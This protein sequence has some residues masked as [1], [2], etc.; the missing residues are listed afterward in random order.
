MLK[1]CPQFDNGGNYSE[2]EIEWYRGQ[3]S[4]IDQMFTSFM[5]SRSNDI[6]DINTQ[7]SS[8][9]KDPTFEFNLAYTDSIK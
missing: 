3:M 6:S 1:S 5:E 2:E 8:L 7:A 4:E 9:K